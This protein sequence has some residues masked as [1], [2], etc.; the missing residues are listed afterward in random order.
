MRQITNT[1][2]LLTLYLAHKTTYL[3]HI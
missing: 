2:A 3:Y 1:A